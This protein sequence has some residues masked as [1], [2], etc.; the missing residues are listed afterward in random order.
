[1]KS[2]LWFAT[3][4]RVEEL[5]ANFQ[6]VI[7]WYEQNK[8]ENVKSSLYRKNRRIEVGMKPINDYAIQL[9]VYQ[10]KVD[11]V[12]SARYVAYNEKKNV[13]YVRDLI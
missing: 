4:K 9:I 10:N 11:G 13:V 3:K 5:T 7:S 8:P 2:G 12:K 1:M 6:Q